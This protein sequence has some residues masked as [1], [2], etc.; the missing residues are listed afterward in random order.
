MSVVLSSPEPTVTP[1][2]PAEK[3]LGDATLWTIGVGLA[4]LAHVCAATWYRAGLRWAEAHAT[5][6]DAVAVA[7]TASAFVLALR[8]LWRNRG[9]RGRT[10]AKSAVLAWPWIVAAVAALT[11]LAAATAYDEWIAA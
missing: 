4:M 3:E 2:A 1:V 11:S 10:G 9:P 7:V 8:G 6:R 5:R